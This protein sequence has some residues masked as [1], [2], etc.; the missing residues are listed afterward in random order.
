MQE[1]N[2]TAAKKK[3]ENVG[4]V[5]GGV[6]RLLFGRPTA[7]QALRNHRIVGEDGVKLSCRIQLK[8]QVI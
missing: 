8:T 7:E 6:D 4:D 5:D 3:K 1:A 2:E